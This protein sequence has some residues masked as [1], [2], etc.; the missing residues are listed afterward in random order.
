[1]PENTRQNIIDAAIFIFN[2]DLSAA[3]E[4]VADHALVTRR[5]LHRYFKDR[6]ELLAACRDEMQKSCHQAMT[7]AEQQSD[8]PLE[9]LENLLYAAIDCG[10]KYAFLHKLHHLHG[11]QHTH[12]NKECARYDKTFDKTRMIIEELLETDVISKQLTVEWIEVLLPAVVTAT[13][14]SHVSGKSDMAALKEAAWYS[15]SKGIG[16]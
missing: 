14:N 1:M 10:V 12:H 16:I 6:T 7:L 2:E 3:L 4:K 11:H 8:V 13:I 5:T 15:F 9:K